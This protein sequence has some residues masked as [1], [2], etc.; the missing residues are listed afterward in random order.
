MVPLAVLAAIARVATL[1]LT[2]RPGQ[3]TIQWQYLLRQLDV[4]LRYLV[5]IVVP[6]GQTIFHVVPVVRLADP[7]GIVVVASFAVI[8]LIAWRLRRSAALVT[9]GV[10]WFL[11]MLVP[12]TMLAL[13]TDA[14]PM[15]EHRIYLASCGLFVAGGTAAAWLVGRAEQRRVRFGL[16][17]V[18]GIVV[19][20]LAGRALVRNAVRADPVGLWLE[21][22]QLAPSHPMPHLL[23]AE[24][25]QQEGR[26]DEAIAEYR[27]GIDLGNAYPLAYQQL[28]LTLVREGRFDDAVK[29]LEELRRVDPSSVV[30]SNGFGAIAL[31]KGERDRARAFFWRVLLPIRR[32]SPRCSLSR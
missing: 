22:V 4:V 15:A 16:M 17:M 21:A 32:M 19:L 7:R 13:L 29:T 23:L 20:S 2:E 14:E 10:V 6:E 30:A 24:A 25:L 9:F 5:L 1:L 11:L 3:I 27:T 31:M 12:S 28:A 18:F 26:A 8:L